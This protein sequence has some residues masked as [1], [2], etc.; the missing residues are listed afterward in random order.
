[1]NAMLQAKN[2]ND[3]MQFVYAR[4]VEPFFQGMEEISA[5]E[6]AAAQKLSNILRHA[7]DHAIKH[8]GLIGLLAREDQVGQIRKDT[9]PRLLRILT[10]IFEQ[11]IREGS[12]RPH[13][14]AYT[15]RMFQGL[16]RSCLSCKRMARPA[17]R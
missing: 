7:C 5:S 10:T 14:V 3:L 6:L 13:N 4:L 12:F 9:H 2:K 15:S 8:K 1:M 17:K 11:G 16:R